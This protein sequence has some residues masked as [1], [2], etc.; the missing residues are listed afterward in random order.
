MLG[1]QP[2]AAP[3]Q[4]EVHHHD[5][6]LLDDADQHDD[7][8]HGDDRQIHVEHHQH[9]QRADTGGGQ[10]GNDRDRMNEALIEHAEHDISGEHRRQDQHALPFE[11]ILEHLRRALEA[12]ADRDRQA[13]LALD[14][15]DG[16]DRMPERIARR[17]IE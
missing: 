6:V 9:Q 12:G 14:L 10:A 16:V 7:A 2:D 15:L 3:L 17:E 8:D 1:R 13:K 5:R 11:R 4:R